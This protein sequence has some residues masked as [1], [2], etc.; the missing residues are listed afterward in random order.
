MSK[1]LPKKIAI[2]A[3]KYVFILAMRQ[4]RWLNFN[5]TPKTHEMEMHAV[6]QMRK[7]VA[8][9]HCKVDWTLGL[10]LPSNW[11]WLWY[12]VNKPAK[13][14]KKG[15]NSF[16]HDL[17]SVVSK[18]L[19]S[20]SGRLRKQYNSSSCAEETK[21]VKIERRDGYVNRALDQ[22]ATEG[23]DTVEGV[24]AAA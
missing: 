3:L 5:V 1:T 19:I 18:S 21:R 20:S 22:Q 15:D 16:K 14:A 6:A 8:R 9:R 7:F 11:P 4:H 23:I 24:G 17:S 2:V 10:A 12:D 13:W